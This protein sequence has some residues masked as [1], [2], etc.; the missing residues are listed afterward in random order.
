MK[1]GDIT[2]YFSMRDVADYLNC[3]INLINLCLMKK[4]LSAK[5]HLI[6]RNNE[7]FVN[8]YKGLKK[9]RCIT[10]NIEFNSIKE[11]SDYYNLDSSLISKCCKRKRKSTG[12][13][14]F[15]YIH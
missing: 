7:P 13:K 10:D 15:E 8:N 12:G 9:V 3:S 5:D 6:S 14:Q 11:A 4:R 2:Y 1:T